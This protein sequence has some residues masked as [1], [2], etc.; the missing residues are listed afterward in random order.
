MIAS[1]ECTTTLETAVGR[2]REAKGT[3]AISRTVSGVVAVAATFNLSPG[4]VYRGRI[5]DP[6]KD[7]K[8]PGMTF[9]E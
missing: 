5:A 3:P 2:K 8:S 6:G 1:Y 4:A 9:V 7:G